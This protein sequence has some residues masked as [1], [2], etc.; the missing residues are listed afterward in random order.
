VAGRTY[1]TDAA[2]EVRLADPAELGSLVDVVAGGFLDR[3]TLVRGDGATRL[4]LWPRQTKSGISETYTAQIVYTTGSREAPPQGS[5]P[6]LR[7]RRGTTQV[8]VVASEEIRANEGAYAAHEAAVAEV[9]AAV[10]GRVSYRLTETRP[11]SGVVIETRVDPA[12]ANCTERTL[13]YF[14]GTAVSGEITSGRIVFCQTDAVRPDVVSHELGHSLGL[15]HPSGTTDL[16][17][18]F[19]WPGKRA[20]FSERE[21]TTIG[22]LFERP[23]GNRF[24]DSDRDVSAAATGTIT[25]HC[26]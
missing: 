26:P 8:A 19:S 25:I 5:S 22:L 10:G 2:G 16:M 24:P 9:N 20:S 7:L 15:Q 17:D 3:Q 23:G 21:T 1:D 11:A 13:A 6:L 12:D 18:P 14:A 4:V